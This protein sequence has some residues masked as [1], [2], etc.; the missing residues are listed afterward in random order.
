VYFVGYFS[1]PW[2]AYRKAAAT[3]GLLDDVEA[4]AVGGQ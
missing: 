3:P 2:D 1:V 4:I